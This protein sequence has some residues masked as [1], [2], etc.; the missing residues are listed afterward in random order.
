MHFLQLSAYW[1]I[2]NRP[3]SSISTNTSRT[4]SFNITQAN[5][6]QTRN[7]IQAGFSITQS[8]T[9]LDDQCLVCL[10]HRPG[11]KRGVLQALFGSEHDGKGPTFLYP[12]LRKREGTPW[13]YNPTG[14]KL[15]PNKGNSSKVTSLLLDQQLFPRS[16]PPPRGVLGLIFA[17]FV[18]LASQSPYPIIV[19]FVA[20]YRP[21]LSHFWANM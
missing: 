19:Y 7:V 20:N 4:F 11:G 9:L 14:R 10:Y 8:L 5:E 2:A 1:S 21:H 18:L 17:G 6:R 13:V 12:S 16:S 3:S 15:K